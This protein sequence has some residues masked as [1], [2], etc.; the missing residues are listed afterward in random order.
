MTKFVLYCRM[1]T[2]D[3]PDHPDHEASQLA[4]CLAY[5]EAHTGPAS[6]VHVDAGQPHGDALAEGAQ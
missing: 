2:I 4:R 3:S 5:V 6:V 1:A